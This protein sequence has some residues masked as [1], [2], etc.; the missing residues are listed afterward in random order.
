MPT[1]PTAP[2]LESCNSLRRAMCTMIFLPAN[3]SDAIS[4]S[5]TRCLDAAA[6]K[7]KVGQNRFYGPCSSDRA[8]ARSFPVE[9]RESRSFLR[10]VGLIA[11]IRYRPSNT[12][13]SPRI[14]CSIVG[15]GVRSGLAAGETGIRT[16]GPSAVG[17]KGVELLE[18]LFEARHTGS[19]TRPY[20][21]SVF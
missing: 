2:A 13:A 4:L 21:L 5:L 9:Y 11:D 8:G 15:I 3:A 12:G 18:A 19:C 14:V 1:A 6:R 20:G 17:G 10:P 16:R 7:H